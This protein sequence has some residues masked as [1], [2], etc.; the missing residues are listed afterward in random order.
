MTVVKVMM[1]PDSKPRT[2]QKTMNP[3]R[4]QTPIHAS[5]EIPAAVDAKTSTCD[6]RVDNPHSSVRLLSK[7]PWLR[8]P[9]H[10]GTLVTRL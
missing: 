10:T 7:V 1:I 6:V 9:T 3:A 4:L 8:Q 2:T 5:T